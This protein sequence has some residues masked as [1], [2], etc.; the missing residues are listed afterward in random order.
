M[1]GQVLEV[2]WSRLGRRLQNRCVPMLVEDGHFESVE[3]R[4][5]YYSPIVQP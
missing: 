4:I 1:C 2:V 5:V 3:G